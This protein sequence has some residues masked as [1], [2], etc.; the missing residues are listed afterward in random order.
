MAMVAALVLGLS[1]DQSR[2]FDLG[3]AVPIAVAVVIWLFSEIGGQG[4]VS[5]SDIA[6]YQRIKGLIDEPALTFLSQHDFGASLR[7]SET[8][9]VG[10]I[11][12]WHG[13]GTEF[14]DSKI[15]KEWSVC[16]AKFEALNRL[17]AEKL[18][19]TNYL[20]RLSAIPPGT[21]DWNTPQYL[22]DAVSELNALASDTYKLFNNFDR[23]AR[24]RLNL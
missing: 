14:R 4:A 2:P 23:K 13:A 12:S 24:S 11:C 21:D 1:P 5:A 7:D 9:P 15:Q 18:G 10:E 6:L 17:Y 8:Y 16:R 19:P 20:S 22:S 3:K